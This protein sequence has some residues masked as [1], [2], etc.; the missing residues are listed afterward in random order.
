[1]SLTDIILL[2][3]YCI[4]AA[5]AV[6]IVYFHL[7]YYYERFQKGV[8]S[9]FM[10]AMLLF[11]IAYTFEMVFLLATSIDLYPSIRPNWLKLC[12]LIAHCGTTISLIVLTKLT[13]SEEYG[14]FLCIRRISK[15][16]GSNHAD[17][18]SDQS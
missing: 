5:C 3:L 1:M 6:I 2:V 8:V 15:N 16:G 13:Y 10:L 9:V 18:G 12:W 7:N 4:E 11:I 14:L 17:A